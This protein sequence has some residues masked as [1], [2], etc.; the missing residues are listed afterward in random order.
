MFEESARHG[1]TCTRRN[2]STRRGTWGV[3]EEIARLG[4]LWSSKAFFLIPCALGF[5]P[6]YGVSPACGRLA[7]PVLVRTMWWDLVGSSLGDSLKESGSSLG[8]R[9]EIAGKKT[10]G[11]AAKLPKVARVCGKD[12]WWIS[13]CLKKEDSE[14]DIGHRR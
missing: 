5:Y 13:V 2:N 3:K 6:C 4:M 7:L 14:V 11:L 12:W 9:K 10:G 1:P 8:T